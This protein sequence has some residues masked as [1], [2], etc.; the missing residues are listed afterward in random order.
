[1]SFGL[2]LFAQNKDIEEV[3]SILMRQQ[4]D[5]NKGNIEDFMQGYIVS[6]ELKF[7][8]ADGVIKGFNAT[9]QRYLSTY[10]DLEAMG[11]L[12]FEIISIEK[13]QRK[14]IL[15]NGRFFL[16]RKND[17]PQGVFTLIWKKIK[18][19]WVILLDHTSAKCY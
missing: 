14:I 2:N 4:D 5:W 10:P 17:A 19:N 18:G 8:G 6:D 13:I 11:Q 1:M 9:L 12:K 7:V 15:L 3:K 16:T